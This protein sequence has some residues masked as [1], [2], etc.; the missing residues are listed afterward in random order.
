[1]KPSVYFFGLSSG[2][3]ISYPQDHSDCIFAN[4]IK[5][6][7][8][9]SQII[10]HR[11][12]NLLYYCYLRRIDGDSLFGIGLCLDSIF[13]DIEFLFNTFDNIYADLVKEGALLKM[14]AKAHILWV[15]SNLL[16]DTVAINEYSKKLID[17]ICASNKRLSPLPPV[18]FSISVNDCIELSLENDRGSIVSATQRYCNLYVVKTKSEIERVTSFTNLLRSK[19]KE[20]NVIKHEL[21]DEKRRSS[22]LRT[23]NLNLKAKQKNIIWVSAFAIISAAM[24]VV[25]YFKV[26]NP[27][28]V[29]HYET[30]EFV[31]Y[32]PLKDKKPHGIGVAIYPA[33]DKDG[34]KYYIGNFE[35]GERQDSSAIL[36][37]QDGDYYYGSMKGDKWEMGMLYMNSDNSHFVG[38]FEDNIPSTGKWYDHR[39]LYRLVDGKKKYD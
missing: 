12:D 25:L 36:F 16:S 35:N 7:K 10:L 39:K 5:K 29:T 3:F 20:I 22:D 34:R 4:A 26:I 17:V 14:D 32:G 28:E 38:T 23:A 33:D 31:Y 2:K 30:G 6:V 1:M 18:D 8:N 9:V 27:S 15:S 19:D 24:F 37:Y 11:K 21:S 13:T